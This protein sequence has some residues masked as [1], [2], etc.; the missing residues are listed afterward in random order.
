MADSEQILQL[1]IEE[2]RSGNREEARNLFEL[3]TRQE[4]NNSTAWLWLAGVADNTDQRRAA[5]QRVLELDPNNDM[6]RRGLES[7]GV[8][9]T[10]APVVS[11][12]AVDVDASMR[13]V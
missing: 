6:A 7:L 10:S 11:S 12:P 2:A 3:L 9:S 4:P 8:A 13:C 5:L 1:G